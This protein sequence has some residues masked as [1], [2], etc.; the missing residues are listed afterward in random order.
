M[1]SIVLGS[2]KELEN[3]NILLRCLLFNL[4]AFVFGTN[5]YLRFV[6][7]VRYYE[8]YRFF[9]FLIRTFQRPRMIK[10]NK[11]KSEGHETG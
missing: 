2:D 8:R 4:N 5:I 6:Y 11:R 9:F 7:W 1:G 10:S 3:I